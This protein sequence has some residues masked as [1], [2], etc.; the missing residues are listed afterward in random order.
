[1][2]DSQGPSDSSLSLGIL[3]IPTQCLVKIGR[4]G[5]SLP[6][7]STERP[8]ENRDHHDVAQQRCL[9]VDHSSPILNVFADS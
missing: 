2:G 4:A 8:Q 5:L 7:M 3:K 6:T 9:T 1:M